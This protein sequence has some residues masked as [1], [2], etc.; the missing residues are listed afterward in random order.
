MIT[1][2]ESGRFRV[3]ITRRIVVFPE[4]DGPMITTFSLGATVRSRSLRTW[5]SPNE[6]LIFSS[7]TMSRGPSDSLIAISPL[8]VADEERGRDAHRQEEHA[9]DRVGLH[10]SEA[11]GRLRL[12]FEED[13]AGSDR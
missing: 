12:G 4:P 1:H 3:M 9:H 8:E 5:F 2:P 13:A 7:R 10:R 6:R 11:P